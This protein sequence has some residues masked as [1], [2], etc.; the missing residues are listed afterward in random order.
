MTIS[1]LCD[2]DRTYEHIGWKG[3]RTGWPGSILLL[4]VLVACTTAKPANA[5]ELSLEVA[6][7]KAVFDTNSG[8]VVRIEG[9]SCGW[10]IERSPALGASLRMDVPL[11]DRHDNLLLGHEQDA[12]KVERLPSGNPRLDFSAFKHFRMSDTTYLEFRTEVFN[13][14]NTPM[15]GQPGSLNFVNTKT[16][17]QITSLRDGACDPRQIQFVLKLCWGNPLQPAGDSLAEAI[18]AIRIVQA[19]EGSFRGRVLG[20]GNPYFEIVFPEIWF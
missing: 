10:T 6:A 1:E 17:S 11:P 19:A 12:A 20:Q 5:A 7:L 3:W 15:F 14:T 16:F 9:K 4:C 2:L 18:D 8:A 13:L